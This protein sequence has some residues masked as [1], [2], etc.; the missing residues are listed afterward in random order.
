MFKEHMALASS[1][2]SALHS[3]PSSQ[4]RESLSSMSVTQAWA[5]ADADKGKCGKSLFPWVDSPKCENRM[6]VRVRVM[7]SGTFFRSLRPL[8]VVKYTNCLCG[9][10]RRFGE[11][12]L[13]LRPRRHFGSPRMAVDQQIVRT[14]VPD[15]WTASS[16]ISFSIPFM[17]LDECRK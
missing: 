12:K 1:T 15:I 4:R 13:H 14:L 2:G 11:R 10:A 7:S 5:D 16:Q 8:A 6:P 3:P 9:E 17:G